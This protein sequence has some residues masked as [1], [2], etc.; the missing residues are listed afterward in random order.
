M[1]ITLARVG[2]AD[3]AAVA[4]TLS[5]G[6]K[7]RLAIAQALIREPD[8]LLLDEPTNHLDLEGVL[9]LEELLQNAPFGFVVISHDRYFLEN[10][11]KRVIELNPAYADGFLSISGSY[12]NFLVKRE[13]YLAAQAHQEVA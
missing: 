13:E 6:W 8:L 12:S 7:K 1:E 2:F 10:V 4:H 5:G 9:W 3:K 11:A